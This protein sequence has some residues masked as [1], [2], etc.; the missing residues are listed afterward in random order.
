MTAQDEGR[1][2]HEHHELAEVMLGGAEPGT[3]APGDATAE[4]LMAQA[5]GGWRGVVDSSVPGAVF[6]LVYLVNG[7]QLTAAVWAAVVAGGVIAALRLLRRESLQQV[8]SGFIGIAFAAWLASRTGRAEDFY[9]PG[10]LTNIA[11]AI[12]LSVSCLVGHPL[13]GYGVGAATGD[14]SGWRRVPEQRRA[15][16]LATWFFAAVFA[17]RV[18][19]QVPLYLA[20]WVGPLGV[21]KLVLG[22]PLFALAAYLSYRV[23]TQARKDAPLI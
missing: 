9:L 17:I 8:A 13:L 6:L 18:A 14:L 21:M 16:A 19:V 2:Q 5:I 20:G 1:E 22:W 11:Y 12:G 10:I 3:G 15:Y 7:N 4:Q 23:I